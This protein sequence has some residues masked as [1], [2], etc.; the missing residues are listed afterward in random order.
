MVCDIY[1]L[2]VYCKLTWHVVRYSNNPSGKVCDL[3]FMIEFDLNLTVYKLDF[4]LNIGN[5]IYM[6]NPFTCIP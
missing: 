3:T 5:V 4:D 2:A 6:C 1:T